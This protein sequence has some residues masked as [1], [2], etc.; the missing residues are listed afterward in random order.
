MNHRRTQQDFWASN[1]GG[2]GYDNRFLDARFSLDTDSLTD[3]PVVTRDSVRF[4]IVIDETPFEFAITRQA[5]EDI[6]GEWI[7]NP[8][9]GEIF[10][11]HR[12]DIESIAQSLIEA[13]VSWPN[14]VIRMQDV[15]TRATST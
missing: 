7:E 5:L 12:E 8:D 9:L 13:G 15:Q 10:F 6:A 4:S 14:L 11:R 1:Y 3:Q 2:L